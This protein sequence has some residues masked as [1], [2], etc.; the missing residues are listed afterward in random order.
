MSPW[1]LTALHVLPLSQTLPG[2][3][4]H[5]TVLM[6]YMCMLLGAFPEVV[7]RLREEHDRVFD[8][9]FDKTFQLLKQNPNLITDLDY[10]AAFI[11][12]T[13]RFFP[14][15]QIIRQAPPDM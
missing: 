12:E 11:Q 15:G 7:K 4:S 1:P 6:Q 3:H 5:L 14:P 8:K 10:T 2:A 9:D 13:L